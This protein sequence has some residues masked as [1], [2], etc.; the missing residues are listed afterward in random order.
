MKP[1]KLPLEVVGR[2]S[3]LCEQFQNIRGLPEDSSEKSSEKFRKVWKEDCS[4]EVTKFNSEV[5]TLNSCGLCW[6]NLLKNVP[7]RNFRVRIV[8]QNGGALFFNAITL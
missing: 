1:S 5:L 7:T 2:F 4:R 8:D 3:S 6:K